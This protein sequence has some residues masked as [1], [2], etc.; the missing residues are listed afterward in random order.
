MKSP[1]VTPSFFTS[2]TRELQLHARGLQFCA[3]SRVAVCGVFR[4]RARRL[5]DRASESRKD[6]DRVCNTRP[7]HKYRCVTVSC[8]LSCYSVRVAMLMY[9]M[10]E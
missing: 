7:G 3:W 2:V 5:E 9:G 4:A 10:S 1:V 8:S 6:S